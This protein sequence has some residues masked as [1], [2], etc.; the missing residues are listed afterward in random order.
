[1]RHGNAHRKLNRT[2]EHRRAM[3]A[4]MANALIKHEQIVTT[5]P[6]AKELRPIVEK[7]VTLGKRGDL[8]ARRQAV[9]ELRDAAMVKKLFDVLAAAL[10]GSQRRLYAGAQGWLP[11][12]RFRS[13]RGDRIC[14]PRRRRKGAGFRSRAGEKGHGGGTGRG[15]TP[16]FNSCFRQGR[17]RPPFLFERTWQRLSAPYHRFA[18]AGFASERGGEMFR[19]GILATVAG[20]ALTAAASAQTAL[21]RGSYLVNTVMSCGNCHTPKGPKGV[22]QNDR[23][24]SGGLSFDTPAFKVTAS[25]ITQDPETGIG[26]WSDADIKRLLIDGVRPNGVQVAEIMPTGFYKVLT[27]RDL[28]AIVVYLK[29]LK[30]IK[31]QVPDP[32]YLKPA[33]QAKVPNGEKRM[34]E[35][36]LRDQVKR[37]FYLAT[38]AHCF[39]CH[40]PLVKGHRDLVSDYG[41]GGF[42]IPRTLGCQHFGQY[43]LASEQGPRRLERR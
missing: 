8:H 21:E 17:L 3:F 19:T 27:V 10:P 2:A 38:I 1:M 24:F 33:G 7:L 9:A 28:D 41:K 35:A 26:K 43:H 34:A 32:V 31:N 14:R 20:L 29:T 12:R 42:E 23:A 18:M 22:P 37:G 15:V 30:P 39:E 16:G 6:K 13:G 5:L 4:N 25:N 11:L 36:D 40:T